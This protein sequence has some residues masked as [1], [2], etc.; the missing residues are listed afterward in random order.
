MG[1]TG[2]LRLAAVVLAVMV[3]IGAISWVAGLN[4]FDGDDGSSSRATATAGDSPDAQAP[5]A[6]RLE[7]A[8][9]PMPEEVHEA[10]G[11][12]LSRR[13]EGVLWTHGDAGEPVIVA[14]GEDGQARGVTR[15]AGATV[16]NWEDIAAGPCPGGDCLYIADIG[17]NAANRGQITVYRVPEPDPGAASTSPAE[18][19]HASYP[20]GSHDAEAMFLDSAGRIYLVTKG[21]TGPVGVYRF[22]PSP[23]PGAT[24]RLEKVLALTETELRRPERITGA[25]ASPDGR[26]VALRT[27]KSVSIYPLGSLTGAD[28]LS[29]PAEYDVEAAG[30]PQGEGIALGTGGEVFLASEGGRKRDPALFTRLSC[31]TGR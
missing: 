4:D 26:S 20:D 18:A 21:E 11:L 29:P 12:A 1:D 22:P 23:A 17:D 31:P 27:L 19:L 8:Q 16:Q 14:V 30:E 10:S 9:V 13:S 2:L 25:S 24:V 3:A 15:V 6:C 28:S 7:G 5:V